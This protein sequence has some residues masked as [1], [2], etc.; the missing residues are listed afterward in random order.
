MLKR[1]FA[2][3]TLGFFSALMVV[4]SSYG[5]SGESV[6]VDVYGS[7]YDVELDHE[8]TDQVLRSQPWWGNKALASELCEALVYEGEEIASVGYNTMEV[9]G[10]DYIE[11]YLVM[12]SAICT[13]PVLIDPADIGQMTGGTFFVVSGNV[14]LTSVADSLHAQ[15]AK[16]RNS[17]LTY[18][19]ASAIN[20][21]HINNSIL[22]QRVL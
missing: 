19:S 5:S 22:Y 14:C 21:D 1:L 15:T 9:R 20:C 4:P 3:T 7:S 17:D 11:A 8:V 18:Q 12:P 2:G 16:S 10:E 6:T 13:G